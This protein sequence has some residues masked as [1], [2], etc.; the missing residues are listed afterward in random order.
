ML[1]RCPP[2]LTGELHQVRLMHAMPARGIDTDRPDMVQTLDEAEH[3]GRLCRRGHLAQP[4]EPALPGLRP[5]LCQRIE[6]A[7]SLGGQADGQPPLYLPPRPKAEINAKPFEAPRCRDDD[8]PAAA[9]LHDQLGQMEEAIVFEG[10][11]MKGVGEF[12]RGIFPE[13][14]EAK[15]VLQFGSM[16]S[17][18]LL[19]GEVVTDG[20][21]PHVDLFGDKRDQGCRRPLIGPQRPPWMAEVAQHQRVAETAVIASAAPNHRKIRLGQRV[22]AN[23]LTWLRGRIEQR[24][25]LGLAQ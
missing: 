20:F 1:G 5:A 24:G 23:Q 14:A 9:C 25:D 7:P 12:G 19:R 3:R 2:G 8:S 15:P 4:D 16:S 11:R 6:L 21:R 10:L 22:I 13:G 18:I 17:A